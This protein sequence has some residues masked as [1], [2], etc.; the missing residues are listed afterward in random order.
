MSLPSVVTTQ[1]HT[2]CGDR[3]GRETTSGHGERSTGLKA[4]CH[5]VYV[6]T[7]QDPSGRRDEQL[8]QAGGRPVR[9]HLRDRRTETRGFRA[10]WRWN[11]QL[12]VSPPHS[13]LSSFTAMPDWPV[14]RGLSLQDDGRTLAHVTVAHT[15][16]PQLKHQLYSG[17]PQSFILV[18]IDLKTHVGRIDVHRGQP[19]EARNH[20]FDDVEVCAP[21]SRRSGTHRPTGSGSGLCLTHGFPACVHLP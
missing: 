21:T 8:R 19:I 9:V 16:D 18:N 15:I 17:N 14:G 1:A 20:I 13:S 2:N 3:W 4:D 7:L 10:H 5:C 6:S 11:G 12:I